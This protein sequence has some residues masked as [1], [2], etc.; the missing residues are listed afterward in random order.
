MTLKPT[1]P[2]N[3]GIETLSNQYFN[4]GCENHEI[5]VTETTIFPSGPEPPEPIFRRRADGHSGTP[6]TRK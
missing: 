1:F 6:I 5:Q 4:Q 3:C 2:E